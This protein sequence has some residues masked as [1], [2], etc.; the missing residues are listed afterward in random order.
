MKTL[1]ILFISF[2]PSV[3]YAGIFP[4][5][6]IQS[7]NKEELLPSR[8]INQLYEDSDGYIW[9][10]T[11]NGLCR[12]DGYT[13]KVYK[14]MYLTPHLLYNNFV[15]TVFEDS[16][17]RLWI[18]TVNGI[19]ILDKRT[20]KMEAIDRSRLSGN[21]IWSFLQT[22][23]NTL[24]IGSQNGLHL[25]NLATDS[26]TTFKN[27]PGDTGS[28]PGND[29]RVL[30]Q[31]SEGYIWIGT[32]EKGIARL[33]PYTYECISYPPLPG[34]NRISVLY[35]DS[36]QNFWI[37]AW[38]DGLHKLENRNDPQQAFYTGH[39]KEQNYESVIHSI[40]EDKNDN[41]LIGTS[42][43]L[44]ILSP[45]Y[46]KENYH[47]S[48][49]EKLIDI[50]NCEI[51]HL[52]YGSQDIIW[53]ATEDNGV[54]LMYKD[55]NPFVNYPFD[56]LGD[57]KQPLN[58]NTIF[59]IGEEEYLLGA[60]KLGMV[61]FN[62]KKNELVHFSHD[63]DLRMFP[64][65]LGNIQKFLK[66][67]Q[68]NQILVG[69]EYGGLMIWDPQR[70]TVDQYYPYWGMWITGDI[71]KA[72]CEDGKQNIWIGTNNGLNILTATDT[73]SY[74]NLNEDEKV[75]VQSILQDHTG[76]IWMGTKNSGIYT[77][78][79][80]DVTQ[81]FFE[82]YNTSNNRINNDEIKCLYE[83]S[84]Q[85]L[86]AGTKGGGLSLLNRAN[87]R[88]EIINCMQEIPGD[89]IFSITEVN[90][91]LF[92][93]TNQG[94]VQFDPEGAGGNQIKIF[95]VQDG[96]LE[97]TFNQQAVL[98]DSKGCVLFGTPAG[99]CT[100][101]PEDLV[102][103]PPTVHTVISN[104]HIFH[105]PFDHLPPNK[106]RKIS[107]EL[108]PE[109]SKAITLTHKDYN[110]GIE[111]ASLT[112]KH[113]EKNRYAYILEGF[114]K[115]WNYVDADHRFAY[116]TNLKSGKYRF[117]VKGTNK[118]SFM[119]ESP[120]VLEITV[121]PLPY[122][123]GWAYS[124]YFVIFFLLCWGV[125]RFLNYRIRMQQALRLEQIEHAKSEE[126]AQTKL[127]FFTNLSHEL[128]TPLSIINCSV[129]EL[130]SGVRYDENIYRII[131]MNIQRLN[132]LLEQVLEFRKAEHGKLKLAVAFGDIGGYIYRIC[133]DNFTILGKSKEIRLTIENP[134]PYIPAWFDK[135][136]IDK[137]MYN[138]LSNA[139]KY[140]RTGGEVRVTILPESPIDEFNYRYLYVSVANTGEG[141][142]EKYLPSLFERFYEIGYKSAEKRGNGIGLSLTKNLVEI[143][144]GSI[145]VESIPGEWTTFSFRIPIEK[146]AYIEYHPEAS[147]PSPDSLQP[148]S[149]EY[150][151]NNPHPASPS[152]SL[153]AEK[154]G[155]SMLIVEDHLELLN[156]LKNLL[157]T[158]FTIV[159]A[160]DGVQ[161]VNLARQHNPDLILSDVMMPRMNG[162]ELCRKIKEE[163]STCHIP[164]VLLTAKVSY[165]DKMEG[166]QVHADAY[167]TKPFDFRMLEAQLFSMIHNHHLLVNK[168]KSTPL[169]KDIR[170]TFTSMDEK[171]LNRAIEVVEKNLENPEFDL[172]LFVKEMEISNSMLYRKIKSLTNL[173]PTEF[174]KNIRLKAAC[175]LIAEGKGNVSEIAYKVGFNDAKYFSRCFKKEFGVTPLEYQ[176]KE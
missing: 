25:Y 47:T 15:N 173:S 56:G 108:H 36:Q 17:K 45:P 71:V 63:K 64:G 43:G 27:I 8:Q 114:D 80:E 93:G 67:S 110:F 152:L 95:T 54:Y 78:V 73:L 49:K 59:E 112:Y 42:L 134:V 7:V 90:D 16:H 82:K 85:R 39:G 117:L 65:S 9:I 124:G 174:I 113:P 176:K 6:Q 1:V 76:R 81:L 162:F 151:I 149:S 38:A 102:D 116:Y 119:D 28:I 29:I 46:S 164:V 92:I 52:L 100:F 34:F 4:P 22:D 156:S 171:I 165:E 75:E 88:F 153:P 122:Q 158:R 129:E 172:T 170:I 126:L 106:Q 58:I 13:Y 60:N 118:N 19:N 166:F 51:N 40:I 131:R 21:H 123:T 98:V 109:F 2:I 91:L 84:K 120:Q 130:R 163:I 86:W 66:T 48:T 69:S 125:T 89:A 111:F 139:F 105:E 142:P 14:A 148:Q 107:P 143:H 159:T 41:L 175:H 101:Y 135:D 169:T 147:S 154:T 20:G 10:C 96:L 26:I 32:W 127:R 94:L 104:I 145:Q 168:F 167:I 115:E 23:E 57:F 53:I 136:K 140:N 103:N 55:E 155:Y 121:L 50:P 137:I 144:Q 11:T 87:N 160:T 99:L 161:G 74:I 83:D 77:T 132:R 138:L 33:N 44:D 150:L 128:L 141:I 72:L 24:W 30:Y 18:G 79:P 62:K 133:E 146:S 68:K 31:D 12:Y 97:N 37:G 70:Q 5:M 61:R 3:L 157:S 35:E